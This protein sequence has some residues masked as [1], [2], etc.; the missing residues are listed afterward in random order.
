MSYHNSLSPWVIYR[1]LPDFQRQFIER[2]R[3][4]THAEEYLKVIQHLSPHAEFE[5]VTRLFKKSHAPLTTAR[6][7]AIVTLPSF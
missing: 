5:I 7:I 3:R 4:R 6:S 1:H 2:F